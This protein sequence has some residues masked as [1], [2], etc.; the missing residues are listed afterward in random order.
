MTN[1]THARNKNPWLFT[2]A[3]KPN[4]P[5]RLICFPYAGGSAQVYRNWH[6]RLPELEVTALQYPGRGTRMFEPPCTSAQQMVDGITEALLPLLDRPFALFGYSLGSLLAFEVARNL[7][8]QHGLAPVHLFVAARKAPQVPLTGRITH[9]LSDP[10]FIEEISRMGG[11]PKEILENDDL[12]K[13]V[14]PTLRADFQVNE[15]YEFVAEAPFDIPMTA[16]GGLHDDRATEAQIAAWGEHTR[17][18]F[19]YRM[20]DGDHF[21]L[22]PLEQELVQAVANELRPHLHR[23]V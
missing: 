20:F 14:L 3:P 5:L 7:R 15:T 8:R 19:E 23:K 18:A 1:L 17:A 22:N 4:P 13:L 12:M 16:F 2:Q 21:F 9:K 11:T 6:K 10:E